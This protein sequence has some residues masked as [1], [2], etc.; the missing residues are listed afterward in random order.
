MENIQV[1]EF[2]S[3]KPAKKK[4]KKDASKVKPSKLGITY[5]FS[6]LF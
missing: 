3:A 1:F 6:S 4:K 2:G 5:Q